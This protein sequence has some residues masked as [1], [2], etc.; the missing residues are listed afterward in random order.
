MDASDIAKAVKCRVST[1]RT[2]LL[3]LKNQDNVERKKIEQGTVVIDRDED[4]TRP[5]YVFVYSI[6]EKGYK[7]LERIT[8]R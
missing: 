4:I 6:T 1:A 5:R 8:E 3:N 2:T 7:R